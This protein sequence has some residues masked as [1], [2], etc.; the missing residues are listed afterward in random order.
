MSR[1]LG[2]RE[3]ERERRK[4]SHSYKSYNNIILSPRTLLPAVSVGWWMQLFHT[5]PSQLTTQP[6]AATWL[7]AK[8]PQFSHLWLGKDNCENL[9][10]IDSLK[11]YL[12]IVSR[13]CLLDAI[14]QIHF[15]GLPIIFRRLNI[16]GCDCLGCFQ[17]LIGLTHLSVSEKKIFKSEKWIFVSLQITSENL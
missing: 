13:I 10:C 7:G 11:F 4:V 5:S 3:R 2:L 12:K 8:Q 15:N 16:F 14:K 9:C 17:Q 6:S 1:E